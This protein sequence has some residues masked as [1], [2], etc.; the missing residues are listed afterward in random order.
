M[1]NG[2]ELFV[3]PLLFSLDAETAHH[4]TIASLRRASHFDLALRALRL[5]QPSS[6][7]KTLLWSDLP[8]PNWTRGRAGQKRCCS[9]GVGSA[10]VR[11]YRDRD[12]DGKGA[13][14]KSQAAHFSIAA[15]NK[16]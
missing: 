11:F 3:R 13:A 2:Y 8:K 15:S 4:L 6:K 16:R 9:S 10:W 7:P 1:K 14:W 12:R 5:Y